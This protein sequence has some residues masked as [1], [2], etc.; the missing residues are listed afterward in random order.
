M[1]SAQTHVALSPS[2]FTFQTVALGSIVAYG[3]TQAAVC[4]KGNYFKVSRVSDVTDLNATN[5]VFFFI[6]YY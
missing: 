6:K 5:E 3:A 4:N 1:I 2:R